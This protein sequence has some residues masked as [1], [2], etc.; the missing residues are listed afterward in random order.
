[1]A[2]VKEMAK[3]KTNGAHGQPKAATGLVPREMRRAERLARRAS[4]WALRAGSPFG[5]MRRFAEEMDRLFEEFGIDSGLPM[6]RLFGHMGAPSRREAGLTATE[7]SPQ[8]EVVEREG[9]LMVRADLPGLSRDDIKV[10]V[11]DDEI[12]IQGERKEEKHE[13]REG[14]CY[15]ECSYGSFFRSIPLPEGVDASKA[16][17]EFCNGV[18]EIALPAPAAARQKAR[19]LEIREKT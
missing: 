10:E 17:A 16:S 13:E 15:S 14:Y 19:R 1:M 3:P 4:S 6:P 8:V 2:E 18:L 5:F 9:K 12:T 11:T 7:W